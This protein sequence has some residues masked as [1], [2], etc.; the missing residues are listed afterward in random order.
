MG[1]KLGVALAG[2]GARGA[3]QIAVLKVLKEHGL[4]DNLYA[5]SGASVGSL[6]AVI[7]AS[8]DL[9]KAEDV[10]MSMDHD[11]L[12]KN[13]DN[14]LKRVFKEK[15]NFIYKGVYQTDKLEALIDEMLDFDKIQDKNVFVATSEVGEEDTSFIELISLNIRDFFGKE[16]HIRYQSLKGMDFEHAKRTLLASCA[17]PVIFKPVVIDKKTYYDG[18]VLDNLPIQPL[19]DAGCDEIIA[20]DLFRFNLTRK[21]EINGIKIKH[22]YP[23][24]NL[25]GVMDFRKEQ[26][27]RRYELGIQD[28]L[29]ILDEH[30]TK[31]NKS[32]ESKEA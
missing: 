21:K 11:S 28:A 29:R 18:G 32:I 6:N 1:K 12:F 24:K 14:I 17:I 20:I 23:S 22:F 3:Y 2:G 16:E 30:Q 31:N 7:L 9:D 4:L 26:I 13:E 27:Q 10:W 25:R 19:I 15:F 8:N 5:V